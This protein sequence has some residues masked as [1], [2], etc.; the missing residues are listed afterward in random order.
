MIAK[1]RSRKILC[2]FARFFNFVLPLLSLFLILLQP[3]PMIF[4]LLSDSIFFPLALFFHFLLPLLESILILLRP[5]LALTIII[6]CVHKGRLVF[7]LFVEGLLLLLLLHEGSLLLSYIKCIKLIHP[8]CQNFIN[9][10]LPPS[11]RSDAINDYQYHNKNR[12][13][14]CKSCSESLIAAL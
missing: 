13:N 1:W 11:L 4:L 7:L 8:L 14:N 3:A 6:M 9:C 10:S 5:S 2:P 12:T